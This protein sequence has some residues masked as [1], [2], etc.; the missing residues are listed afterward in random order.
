[1][2][3][4]LALPSPQERHPTTAPTVTVRHQVMPPLYPAMPSRRNGISN[5]SSTTLNKLPLLRE[6][7]AV[8]L[9]LALL[10][11]WVRLPARPMAMPQEQHR[12]RL[13]LHHRKPN[14]LRNSITAS[15]R[16]SSRKLD[17]LHTDGMLQLLPSH[18]R[19]MALHPSLL[20]RACIIAHHHLDSKATTAVALLHPADQRTKGQGRTMVTEHRATQVD[21]PILPRPHTMHS[22]DLWRLVIQVPGS[23]RSSSQTSAL[24]PLLVV[25]QLNIRSPVD[26]SLA[27][28]PYRIPVDHLI[29]PAPW[30][31]IHATRACR[32]DRRIIAHRAIS[33][34]AAVVCMEGRAQ[35]VIRT[36]Q[37]DRANSMAPSALMLFRH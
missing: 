23:S 30:L 28:W 1:M 29:W 5:G 11:V 10:K 27:P 20:I 7:R 19:Y 31:P 12:M 25:L 3:N 15:I 2:A 33:I 8:H 6:H 36:C 21:N 32:L 37:Q 14:S 34:K 22:L 35:T 9:R 16:R 18:S 24:L 13:S 26:P 17:P 4:R